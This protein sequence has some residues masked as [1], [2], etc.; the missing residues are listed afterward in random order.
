MMLLLGHLK[1][2]PSGQGKVTEHLSQKCVPLC[3]HSLVLNTLRIC[4]EVSFHVADCGSS[5]P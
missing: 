1:G 5:H 2:S 4:C 3:G